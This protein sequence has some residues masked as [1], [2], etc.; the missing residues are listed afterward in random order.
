[1]LGGLSLLAVV[2]AAVTSGFVSRAQTRGRIDGD[3]AVVKK[4]EELTTELNA[5]RAELH[6]LRSENDSTGP[7]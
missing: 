2:T 5:V 3:D 7:S 4:I 1:M 6:R